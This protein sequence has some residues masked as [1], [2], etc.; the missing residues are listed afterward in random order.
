MK[1]FVFLNLFFISFQFPGI[2]QD[3]LL[4]K[5]QVGLVKTEEYTLLKEVDSAYQVMKQAALNDGIDI[6]V[7]SS[8][9]SFEH[10]KAIWNRKYTRYTNKGMPADEAISK[11]VKYSTIPGTS[12]HHW[13]TDIDIIQRNV[14]QPSKSVLLEENYEAGGAYEKLKNWMDSNAESFGFHLVYTNNEN[15][16]GFSYEPWHYTYASKSK[17]LLKYY[18]QIDILSVLKSSSVKGSQ[19][20]DEEFLK[21]YIQEN[22]LDINPKLK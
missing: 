17:E 6:Q 9:R 14:K 13:G 21:V 4:G 19:Y 10:Q 5:S 8:Y 12:R 3:F 2:T 7:V 18:R 22:I 15:R 16:K 11:I 20:F 1:L